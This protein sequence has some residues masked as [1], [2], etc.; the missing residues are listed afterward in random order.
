[1]HQSTAQDN[2]GI[3]EVE[4]FHLRYRIEG[5]GPPCLVVGSAICY[6]RMFSQE[7][8]ENLQ[9]VFVDLRH[10][11]A[12]ADLS[13]SPSSI[14]VDTYAGDIERVRQSLELGDVVVIGHSTHA[15]LA[16]EYARQYPEHVRGVVAIGGS[17]CGSSENLAAGVRLWEAEA[18]GER[19]EILAR[20]LAE[21]T[22]EVRAMLSPADMYVREYV[23]YGPTMW[24]DP[25]RDSSWLWGAVVPDMP[26][27]DRLS[28]ELFKT[29]DLAQGHAQITVPTLIACGRHDYAAPYTLWEEHRHKLPRHTYVLFEKSGHFPSLE[30]PQRFDQMLLTWMHGLESSSSDACSS[31]EPS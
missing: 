3:M 30:E 20:Q 24:F 28:G 26:I 14:T 23:A 18:S 10:F 15:K 4:G 21:L 7:L 29:Y 17:P 25:T 11:A 5:H 1:M 6:P 9:L 16:L 13:F 2:A 12:S 31:T 27:M 19:K 22:P 8:R